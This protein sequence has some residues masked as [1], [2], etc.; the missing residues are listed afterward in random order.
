MPTRE[1]DRAR[2]LRKNMTLTEW[3][4]WLKLRGRQ[5]DGWK[6]RRQHPIG[7]Y[8]VDFYCPAA[9]L[10]VE[11]DGSSHDDG[12]AFDYG[13]RRQAWLESQG[14]RVLRF[15]ADYPEQNYLEGVWDTIEFELSQ[16]A[17]LRAPSGIPNHLPVNDVR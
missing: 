9:R 4:L 2:Y 16:I 3:R 1:T 17:K 12:T 7:E 5:L 14:Y 6:F 11:L 13:Q 10:V 8:I 15:R